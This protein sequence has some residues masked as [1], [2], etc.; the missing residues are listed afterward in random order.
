MF[1]LKMEVNHRLI[2][3][4]FTTHPFLPPERISNLI[5]KIQKS[6]KFDLDDLYYHVL[7]K[8]TK[9]PVGFISDESAGLVFLVKNN[10]L[11]QSAHSRLKRIFGKSTEIRLPKSIKNHSKSNYS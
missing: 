7:L 3:R 11:Y 5:L 9:T 10:G 4:Y 6:E 1:F 2:G 8:D